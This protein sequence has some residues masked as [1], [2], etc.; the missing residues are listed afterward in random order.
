MQLSSD[1]S[2]WAELEQNKVI[3][4]LEDKRQ[5]VLGDSN[6]DVIL[7]SK[8]VRRTDKF[9]KTTYSNGSWIKRSS[10]LLLFFFHE[11]NS[12]SFEYFD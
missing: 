10:R 7:D 4:L 11:T 9:N 8:Y 12:S 3:R 2:L 1:P 6:G 5:I